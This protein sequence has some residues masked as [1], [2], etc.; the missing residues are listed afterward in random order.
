MGILFVKSSIF[1]PFSTGIDYKY[2]N[3]NC[4]AAKCFWYMDQACRINRYVLG[5]PC[6]K[7]IDKVIEGIVCQKYLGC[8]WWNT[9]RQKVLHIR[10][11]VKY[12]DNFF[13]YI[14]SNFLL[15]GPW[16]NYWLVTS[17]YYFPIRSFL[18]CWRL[19]YLI[20]SCE[21]LH[22]IYSHPNCQDISAGQ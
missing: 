12:I 8:F 13:N 10:E 9:G 22:E 21:T 4:F 18:F 15:I 20:I 2:I 3:A 14:S 6:K 17:T 11:S 7:L 5:T 1:S 19:P 16:T